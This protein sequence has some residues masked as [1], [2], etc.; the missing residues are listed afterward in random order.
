MVDSF[1]WQAS[2]QKATVTRS[3]PVTSRAMP[4]TTI[5][6]AARRGSSHPGGHHLQAGA[7]AQRGSSHP[8]GHHL[9]AGSPWGMP[10]SPMIDYRG[11]KV[12][13]IKGPYSGPSGAGPGHPGALHSGAGAV[14]GGRLAFSRGLASPAGAPGARSNAGR[15]LLLDGVVCGPGGAPNG[16]EKY[17]KHVSLHSGAG[18]VA[19]GRLAFSRGLASPAGAPGARANAG[20]PLL[21][22]GVVCGPGRPPNGPEKWAKHVSLQAAAGAVAGGRLAFSHSPC[23]ASHAH[24]PCTMTLGAVPPVAS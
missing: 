16:P 14:A 18:A 22:G 19:G 24:A 15:P 17:A 1:A 21:L 6:G 20:R 2:P 10:S 11:V 9:Q 5:K 13:Q 12:I 3:G 7:G 23:R 4:R 8:G